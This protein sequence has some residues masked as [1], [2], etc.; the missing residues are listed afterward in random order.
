[1]VFTDDVGVFIVIIA[2]CKKDST[3]ERVSVDVV[4]RISVVCICESWFRY[5]D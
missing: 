3:L 2:F 1:M 5:L 4:E